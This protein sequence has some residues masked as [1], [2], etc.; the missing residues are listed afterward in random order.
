MD[1]KGLWGGDKR[2][3][4][5]GMEKFLEAMG[6]HGDRCPVCFL[7]GV[8]GAEYIRSILAESVTDPDT[9]MGLAKTDG[10]C[11][12]HAWK[13]VEQGEALGMGV[14]YEWF[15]GRVA[16]DRTGEKFDPCPVCRYVDG[17]GRTYAE[18]F[19]EWW[20][21]SGE[22]QKAIRQNNGLCLPHI[23]RILRAK[24]KGPVRSDLE[25]LFRQAAG[26]RREPLKR[27]LES[28]RFGSGVSLEA[29]DELS[30]KDVVRWYVG[31][32]Q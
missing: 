12:H 9:R 11:R 27:Y 1:W 2:M 26:R 17:V 5:D 28:Q 31:D 18:R 8:A 10:F 30:W 20:E 14:I 21:K 29:G 3:N 4:A 13:A 7:E 22:F 23:R 24:M 32:R 25:S 16:W 6:H 19:I 15:L